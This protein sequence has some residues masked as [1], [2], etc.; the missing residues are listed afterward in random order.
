MLVG[1]D[2]QGGVKEPS[3][4][5]VMKQKLEKLEDFEKSTAIRI[6]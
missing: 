6:Y 4:I 1:G 3:V 2:R 5:Q